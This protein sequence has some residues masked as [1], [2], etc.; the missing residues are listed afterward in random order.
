M[1]ALY[2][3]AVV[4]YF[5]VVDRH[6]SEKKTM[7]VFASKPLELIF[8]SSSDI[9]GV[10]FVNEWMKYTFKGNIFNIIT[11]IF[12]VKEGTPIVYIGFITSF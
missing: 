2:L 8:I 4:I 1:F 11:A 5:I 6:V 12:T 3:A 7:T 9:I 10:H